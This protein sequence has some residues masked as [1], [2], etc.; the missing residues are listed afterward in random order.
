MNGW[1]FHVNASVSFRAVR[2]AA[3]LTRIFTRFFTRK[4]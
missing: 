4:L 2:S 1:S 3:I